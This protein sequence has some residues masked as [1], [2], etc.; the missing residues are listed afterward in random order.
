MIRRTAFLLTALVC[1][2]FT[3]QTFSPPKTVHVTVTSTG[4]GPCTITALGLSRNTF[5]SNLANAPVGSLLTTTSGSCA[6]ATYAVVSTNGGSPSA[7]CNASSG[8]DFSV[9]GS[10][11]A[12]IGSPGANTY[13]NICFSS[14]ISGASGS[15]FVQAITITGA[16]V[17]TLSNLTVVE[18]TG[19]TQTNV[20]FTIGV[21]FQSGQMDGSHH[22]VATLSGT[23]LTC[24]EGNTS[25]DLGN[26]GNS[27]TPTVRWRG[28]TCI[29]PSL[30]ASSTASIALAT[31]S[32]A[33]GA[34]TD[35]TVA[36]ITSTAY[37]NL[38]TIVTKHGTTETASPLDALNSGHTAWV[39]LTHAAVLGK[40]RKSDGLVTGFISFVPFHDGGGTVDPDGLYA[41]FDTECYKGN[42]GAYD[43]PS[44]GNTNP[45]LLCRTDMLIGA[46]VAQ[47]ASPTDTWF[48]LTMTPTGCNPGSNWAKSQPATN[49]SIT[50]SN[51]RGIQAIT[52]SS[53]TPFSTT[54][55]VGTVIDDGTG[56]GV[57]THVT[58]TTHAELFIAKP[59][60]GTTLSSGGYSFFPIQAPYAS[61][62][63]IRCSW[64]PG[65][66]PTNI[67]PENGNIYLGNPWD[68]AG[69]AGIGPATP[70][71][72]AR[73][74]PN[75]DTYVHP[76]PSASPSFGFDNQPASATFGGIN[77]GGLGES[78]QAPQPGSC[79]NGLLA[80]S[81][82]TTGQATG[83]YD[84]RAPGG[85]TQ[86][87][88]MLKWDANAVGSF[89]PGAMRYMT[90]PMHFIDNRT[91]LVPDVTNSPYYGYATYSG[92]TYMPST[93]FN[94]DSIQ[95]WNGV[96]NP[97]HQPNPNYLPYFFTGD[98]KYV[99][100]NA[101]QVHA[102]WSSQNPSYAGLGLG[103]QFPWNQ[104]LDGR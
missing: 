67:D 1:L 8:T 71:I 7:T 103:N 44:G 18:T 26:P 11:V 37:D 104:W 90:S 12:A 98:W 49:I 33:P 46:G 35:L 56:Y 40:W 55:G 79:G 102:L 3:A 84:G 32:G 52:A 51:V 95:C 62:T 74:L 23:P 86:I 21:P 58:D 85:T 88:A 70:F 87:Q 31:T 63:T 47:N 96:P 17:A 89:F 16:P 2:C 19:S 91:G 78:A 10:A 94:S 69:G 15:P 101:N 100:A 59:F 13:S 22:V 50:T 14:T 5:D 82:N 25:S 27:Y 75:Y 41:Y 64:A 68:G 65:G 24:G 42:T 66:T 97:G 28:L 83:D 34:G 45:I 81:Y 54:S 43:G 6:S 39:D 57:L 61:R 77:P 99:F 92:L 9:S 72:N 80:V 30:T 73:F 60:A 76:G 53:G 20:P 38:A 48:G 29:I 4:G 93:Q 36:N